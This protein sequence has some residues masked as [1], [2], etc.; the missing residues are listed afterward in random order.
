[1]AQ[2]RLQ[3]A[4]RQRVR[5]VHSSVWYPVLLGVV[6]GWLFVWIWKHHAPLPPPLYRYRDD[7]VITL[8]HAKNLIDFGAI[9]IDPAA[10]RVEGFSTPLQFWLFALAYA[11]TRCGYETFLDAQVQLC[12][13]ALGFALLQL[14]RPHYLWGLLLS[15][16]TALWLTTTAR[17]YGWHHSGM[18]NSL[19]HALLVGSL[20]CCIDSILRRRVHPAMLVCLWLA[21]LT[22]LESIM[23]VAPLIAI[24]AV[25]YYL[26]H[27]DLAAVRGALCVLAGWLGYQLFRVWYFGHFQPNTAIA[28]G[29]DV[30]AALKLLRQGKLLQ[31]ETSLLAL[32]QIILDHR[33]YLVLA[34]V[35]LLAFG[36]RSVA[37]SA[38]VLMVSAL[39]FTTL[40]HPLLFGP[41]RLDP[42]RTTS[43]AALIAPLLLTTQW[44]ALPRTA[45]RV[46]AGA[47]LGAVIYLHVTLA[48]TPER[49]FCCQIAK[50]DAIADSCL[51]RAKQE[52][53]ARAS[54]ANPDLGRISF[55]KRMLLDDLGLLG[56]PPLAVLHGDQRATAAYLLELAAP[57]FIELHGS[58]LCAYDYVLQ[59]P[60]F[61]ER[62]ERMPEADKLGLGSMCRQHGGIWFR[63]ALARGSGTPERALLDALQ[64]RLEPAR[65][66]EELRRCQRQDDRLACVYVAR[67]VQRFTP[68]L[69][70]RGL[71]P[72]MFALFQR[73]P[74]A[75]YDLALLRGRT[76]GTWYEDVTA[77]ARGL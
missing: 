37:R 76:L 56:S 72:A 12:S 63:K 10:A 70:R 54:L 40:A 65:V 26:E 55:G 1:V 14:F 60:R 4:I 29:V 7:A 17:F 31:P 49:Y 13:F 11:V 46:L 64:A 21:S 74:S 61:S 59:D 8:S 69:V 50:A 15:A 2:R 66:A 27:H 23:H 51:A 41:A 71:M 45:A 73:S 25:A 38:L 36:A 52:G 35:P 34:A 20:A 30:L 28:E 68:E 39:T 22:R 43:H 77:F 24:W 47:L 48:P 6:S 5:A 18:E 9:G 3:L 58:W 75:R 67:T 57:D 62:Y 19:S 42:V 53:I 32:R 16:G 33:V 44:L